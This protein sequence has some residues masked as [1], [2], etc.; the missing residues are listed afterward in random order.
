[1]SI[2]IMSLV[3]ISIYIYSK[4]AFAE[5]DTDTLET[6][7][8]VTTVFRIFR[9]AR[10][11]K[12]AKSWSNFNYFLITIGSTLTKISAFALILFLFIFIFAMMGMEFYAQ[13]LRFNFD[14]KP[15]A[16]FGEHENTSLKFSVPHSNFDNFTNA[17]LTVYIVLTN[18]GWVPIYHQYYRMARELGVT[19]YFHFL[20]VF[21]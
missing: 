2:V 10:I 4:T 13:K 20:V 8:N 14:E 17:M 3:D 16:Y 11:L 6:L 21:G 7:R 5:N 18:D 19:I 15:I 12:L 9:L 1:M